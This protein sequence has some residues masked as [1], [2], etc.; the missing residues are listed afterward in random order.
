VAGAHGAAGKQGEGEMNDF[1]IIYCDPAW[2]YSG[3]GTGKGCAGKEYACMDTESIRQLP[4]IKIAAENSV[5]FMWSTFPMLPDALS[6]MKAWGFSYKTIAFV[7]LKQ[8]KKSE[9]DFF[10]MGMWTRSNAEVCLLG[11]RGKP[12][13]ASAAVRQVIRR[14]I[15]R[16]SEKPPEV[17]ER[18]VTLMGDIPRVELFARV[19][20]DGWSVWGNEVTS[21]LNLL[22]L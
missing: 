3:A 19:K 13:R 17:R 12:K 4:V 15:M 21:D 14:P 8:N 10:G 9:S 1:N 20:T 22:N 11:I 2:K 5:C 18:I 7:W 6:V 16:H